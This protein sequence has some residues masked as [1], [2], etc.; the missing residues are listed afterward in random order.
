MQNHSRY[1]VRRTS[2]ESGRNLHGQQIERIMVHVYDNHKNKI[3]YAKNTSKTEIVN[4]VKYFFSPDYIAKLQCRLLNLQY[5]DD[6]LY[7][8]EIKNYVGLK[9]NYT[10][11]STS[12]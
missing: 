8:K 11:S 4:G 10:F 1:E 6:L 3:V 2:I 7:L 12:R 9:S 5:E